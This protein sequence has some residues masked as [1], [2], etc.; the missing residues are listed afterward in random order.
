MSIW[1]E[2]CEQAA[3][4]K[5]IIGVLAITL[6]EFDKIRAVVSAAESMILEER[7]NLITNERKAALYKALKALGVGNEAE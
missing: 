7:S 5:P 3:R 2:L 1:K 6:E 4:H